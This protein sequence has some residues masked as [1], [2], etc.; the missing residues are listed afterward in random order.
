MAMR[1]LKHGESKAVWRT[2]LRRA[3][4]VGAEHKDGVCPHPRC[5]EGGREVAHR[6]VKYLTTRPRTS[7]LKPARSRSTEEKVIPAQSTGDSLKVCT[8]TVAAEVV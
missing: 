7:N 1:E 8:H 4:V 2:S 3:A 5:L 6:L